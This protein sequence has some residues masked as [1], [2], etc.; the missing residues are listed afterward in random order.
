MV[1]GIVAGPTAASACSCA[2][3]PGVEEELERSD[4]VFSG[5]AIEVD[6][7]PALFS[8]STRTIIFQVGQIWKGIEQS[9]VEITTGQGGGDCGFKFNMGQEYLVYAVK[10]EMY[11]TNELITIICD[12]TAV[13]SQAQGDMAILGAGKVPTK[14]VDLLNSSGWLLPLAGFIVFGI[15][16]FIIYL[17]R[18]T[19]KQ[20]G[21]KR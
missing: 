13:L 14:E 10:S 8:A 4:A 18:K 16:A 5:K 6:E 12:R 2:E 21:W 1:A 9:Q 20:G 7:K 17:T 11:G 19:I 15:I 3:P